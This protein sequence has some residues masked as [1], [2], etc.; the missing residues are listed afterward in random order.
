MGSGTGDGPVTGN[1][2]LDEAVIIYEC[3]L[4]RYMLLLFLCVPLFIFIHTINR[5]ILKIT[6]FKLL[7][8]M[9]EASGLG[10]EL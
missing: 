10:F 9:P 6:W 4:L 2:L 8:L 5:N 7:E 1:D 3:I